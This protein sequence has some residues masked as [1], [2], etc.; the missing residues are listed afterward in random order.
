MKRY[1]PVLVM[2]L[3]LALNLNAQTMSHEEEVVRN[4]YAKVAMLAAI[5]TVSENA[6]LP[7]ASTQAE[8]LVAAKIASSQPVFDLSNFQV[9]SIASVAGEN[10]KQYL[11]LATDGQSVLKSMTTT[12]SHGD[13]GNRTEWIGVKLYWAQAHPHSPDVIRQMEDMN[14][15]SIVKVGSPQWSTVPV[16]YTRYAAFTVDATFA[17][18]STGTH[19]AIFFFGTDPNGKEYVAVNDLLSGTQA[20]WAALQKPMYPTGLL[21]SNLRE[22]PAVAGWL[23]SNEMPVAS[24]CAAGSVA[25]KHDLCCTKGR[26]GLSVTDLNRDLA[27]PLPRPRDGGQQ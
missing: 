24:S 10:W 6:V 5:Q 3:C 23:R 21:S 20:L 16:T 2:A 9:G 17:G 22:L 4:A 18:Q 1:F 11:T 27:A 14:I 15:A 12:F 13:S 26:C 8:S 19:K 7:N 25:G